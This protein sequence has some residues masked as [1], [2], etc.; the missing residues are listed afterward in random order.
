LIHLFDTGLYANP[1]QPRGIPGSQPLDPEL[2]AQIRFYIYNETVRHHSRLIIDQRRRFKT[3]PIHP[4]PLDLRSTA[5]IQFSEGVQVDLILA[6]HAVINNSNSLAIPVP[7]RGS[8]AL[9]ATV[10]HQ[11]TADMPQWCPNS[12]PRGPHNVEDVTNSGARLLP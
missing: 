12:T 11:R 10:H 7:A 4:D 5:Q 6:I 2:R 9:R 8:T 1:P 3:L